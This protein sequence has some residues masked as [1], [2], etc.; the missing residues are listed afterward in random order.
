MKVFEYKLL[1][2]QSLMSAEQLDELGKA[3][4]ELTTIIPADDDAFY[5]FYFKREVLKQ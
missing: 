2:A 4:W 5:F 1:K 3:G